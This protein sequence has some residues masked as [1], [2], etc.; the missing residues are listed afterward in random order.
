MPVSNSRIADLL[1]ELADILEFENANPFRVRAYR[2][3]ARFVRGSPRGLAELVERREDLTRL[4]FIGTSL[5]QKICTIVQTGSLPALD[6][7]RRR[8]PAA[9]TALMRIPGLGPKRVRTLH[10]LLDVGSV[11]D[12]ER[13]A[14][15]GRIRSLR[16]FGPKTEEKILSAI[17]QQQITAIRTDRLSAR[18]VAEPLVAFLAGMAGVRRVTV[19]GS[20]RRCRDTVGDLDI[21]ICTGR[22]AAAMAA[23]VDYPD[24][25]EVIARGTKRLTV[26]LQDGMQ[27]DVRAVPAVSYGAALHY[28]TGSKSHNIAVRTLGMKRH[29]K[30]NEYGVFASD[31]RIGG[32]TEEDVF[33]TVGL[34]YIP[35]ELRENRGEIEAGLAGALP[36]LVEL[37]DIRGD[38][39]CH[40]AASDGLN[41]IEEMA[42][43][44]R[45][46]G[47]AYLAIADHSKHTKVAHGLDA[48]SLSVQLD[49]IDRLN[50]Q[51]DG[52][53]LLKACEVD[54]LDDGT[55]DMPDSILERLDLT[56]CAVHSGFHLPRRRQT[57]RL[58]KAMDHRRCNILA[59]PTGR[60]INERP[61][62]DVDL[63]RVM[64]GAAERG[65]MLEV[66]GQ[67]RRLDLTDDASRMAGEIGVRLALN[68]DA[69]STDSLSFMTFAVD[70]AR[71]GWVRAEDVINTR[72]LQDLRALLER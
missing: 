12:L 52:F 51:L 13:A 36:Y 58:L 8:T 3:A 25:A 5:A 59:H 70:Q 29:L 62:C 65:C 48:A 17:A 32:R 72:S 34:P 33:R 40:T 15:Q 20:Y 27:V 44:A 71:R 68:S 42:A 39:H 11:E 21:L 57:E 46:L 35:P 63:E 26:R 18:S 56:V 30:I 38:L 9:V 28:F 37:A 69:H 1:D 14:R 7:A 16:G 49:E 31:R 67:P 47:Y 24:V 22:P 2:N 23:V 66:N 53:V 61:P 10:E 43:A 55:L 6:Q 50:E 45:D 64:Q 41:T 60:L 54:I 19:A 4:P